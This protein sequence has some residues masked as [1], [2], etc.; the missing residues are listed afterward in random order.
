MSVSVVNERITSD[1]KGEE[2]QESAFSYPSP[3]TLVA[4]EVSTRDKGQMTDSPLGRDSNIA[5]PRPV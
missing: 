4:V 1:V 3:V 5:L 2:V